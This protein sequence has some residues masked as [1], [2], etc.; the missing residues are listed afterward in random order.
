[1]KECPNCGEL[2]GDSVKKCFACGFDMTDEEACKIAEQNRRKN[3]NS[4]FNNQAQGTRPAQNDMVCRIKNI[5]V[6]TVWVLGALL[7]LSLF[8]DT[9]GSGGTTNDGKTYVNAF[10]W[11]NDRTNMTTTAAAVF[12]LIM[13]GATMALY[14]FNN[15]WFILGGCGTGLVGFILAMNVAANAASNSKALTGS[16]GW[17]GSS[18]GK[19]GAG[20]VFIRLFAI[21]MFIG[22][23]VI[24]S[25]TVYRLVRCYTLARKFELYPFDV[26]LP[27][28][29][30]NREPR[31]PHV[32]TQPQQANSY[33][34]PQQTTPYTQ[35]QQAAPYTQPQQAAP[36]TQP[37][38]AASYAQPQQAA[39]Y[40]QPQQAAPYAQPQ[41]AAP[42]AQPQQ[43]TPYAQPQQANPY[44][45]PQQVNPY[46]Q[47][48]QVN[49]YAQ[50]QQADPYVQPQQANPYVQPQKW[51]CTACGAPNSADARF[52]SRCGKPKAQ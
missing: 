20:V 3:N 32:Y 49:P 36:Y 31:Q 12:L 35:P 46:A 18:G 9:L 10:G 2:I 17:Y 23:L 30:I 7:L 51:F 37:Q 48:Q 41:Q 4:V 27:E 40:A 22:V 29:H 47:P 25:L 5:A 44:A 8:F 42:Y 52:C 43:A 11:T 6:I 14:N 13:T 50:P 19:V 21:P 15:A 33:V 1:M 26:V 34:Q 39:S 24:L 16:Y 45:Q 38:Q 28:V